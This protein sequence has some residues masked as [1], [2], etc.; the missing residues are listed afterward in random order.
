MLPDEVDRTSSG[1]DY[2]PLNCQ[3][4]LNQQVVNRVVA[5]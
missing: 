4:V 1:S 3:S 5:N 2:G